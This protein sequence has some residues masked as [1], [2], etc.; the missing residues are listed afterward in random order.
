MEN[1]PGY[2]RKEAFNVTELIE[3]FNKEYDF[4]YEV[5]G[6]VAGYSEAVNWFDE[7]QSRP[8][9]AEIRDAFINARGD[10]I[11]SDREAAAFSFA[12]EK[13]GLI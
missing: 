4:L 10:F 13:L 5:E 8:D 9:V 12:V 11:S 1:Q 2:E 6:P 7:N 3:Q